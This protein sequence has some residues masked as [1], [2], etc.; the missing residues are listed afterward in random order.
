MKAPSSTPRIRLTQLWYGIVLILV[1]VSERTALAGWS[2]TLVGVLGFCMMMAA[3]LGRI[4]TTAHIAG[5]KDAQLITYGPYSVCRHPLYALSLLG[6]TGVGLAAHSLTLALATLVVLSLLHVWAIRMEDRGL[7]A[8]HGEAF[9]RYQREV[10]SLWPDWKRYEP[11]TETALN[12]KVFRK[13]FLDAGTF[14]LYY[15]LIQLLDAGRAA[16]LWPTLLRLW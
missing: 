12:L 3:A 2:A 6:G 7:Q 16:G 14:V 13:A 9:E 4:W 11:R 15:A 8:R 5:Y 1:A 10:P